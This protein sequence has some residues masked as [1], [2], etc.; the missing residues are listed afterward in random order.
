MALR[1]LPLELGP[2]EITVVVRGA[3]S[4]RPVSVASQLVCLCRLVW[5]ARSAADTVAGSLTQQRLFQGQR[6]G[7]V[8]VAHQQPRDE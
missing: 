2:V 4:E 6:L 1:L 8:A 3:R 7:A 5:L